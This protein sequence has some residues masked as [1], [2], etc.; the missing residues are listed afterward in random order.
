[1]SLKAP[2][3]VALAVT[4]T[5]A[6]VMA[7]AAVRLT[8]SGSDGASGSPLG[9]PSAGASSGAPGVFVAG[10]R[11]VDGAGR[12]IVLKGVN[13]SGSE[14]ACVDG[15]GFFDGPVDQASVDAMAS[16]RINT[17]RVP[18]NS[19]C[20]LGISEQLTS[21]NTSYA[22]AAYQKAIEDYVDLLTANGMYVILE[23]HWTGCGNSPCLANWLKPMPER[24]HA[25][26]FWGS[27]A[28]EFKGNT[29]ILFDLF[30]EPQGIDWTC[31]RDGGCTVFEG[32]RANEFTVEGMQPMVDAV[33]EAGA[34]TQPILLGGLE[35][36]NDM[37]GW[38]A[39]LPSDPSNALVASVHLYNFNS[40]CPTMLGS[41]SAADAIECFTSNSYNSI[42]D[43]AKQYPVVFGE[44]GQ[45]GCR[46]DFVDPML[47][48]LDERGFSV[49]GWAWNTAD[50]ASFPALISDYDGTPT[51]FGKAFQQSF[52][53]GRTEPA[54]ATTTE[55]ASRSDSTGLI[56]MGAPAF[57][58]AGVATNGNDADYATS[59]EVGAGE[60]GWLAYDLSAVPV[61]RR[62]SV[63]L[64]WYTAI[65]DG[66]TVRGIQGG[67]PAWSGR[68]YLGEYQI[69][70]NSAP[71]G[72]PAP[73]EGWVTAESV[74]GN[75]N[76]S[77]QHKV[78][79]RGSNWIRVRGSGPNGVAINV[80]VADARTDAHEGWLFLGDSITAGYAGH[81][82]ITD[83]GGA[84]VAGFSSLISD[85]TEGRHRPLSQ[86]SGVACSKASDAVVW[87]D[88]ILEDFHGKYVTLNFGGNDGWAG[89]G[90]PDA[91]YRTMEQ[92]VGIVVA[93]GKVPVVATITWPNNPG[94]WAAKTQELNDQIRKLYKAH[95][96]VLP[97]PDLYGLLAD[98]S[99]L[100]RG[101]GDPHPNDQGSALIRKAWRDM[102]LDRVFEE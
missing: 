4:L 66:H 18:L 25:T 53:A 6:L 33:R 70:V 93:H 74:T 35:Y 5:V 22:G 99:D 92:L 101:A 47:K 81:A 20:W 49:L 78:D 76:L 68:P 7:L 95:P 100:F 82:P 36:A 88:D 34:R 73:D 42:E 19:A 77:G 40:P 89:Q 52:T 57:A 67:C 24:A 45:D 71:G 60:S 14:Y 17:V 27:V 94:T 79:L 1:M 39:N 62:E 50:C 28:A 43:I 69:E 8:T 10:N 12:T 55:P 98:R 102:A 72:G 46:S 21:G 63:V 41:Q 11:L 84:V 75:Q 59:W 65:D 54:P 15:W 38:L 44:L 87:I 26:Q 30:N 31:W 29:S 13:R 64:A 91:Y 16:W 61:D 23:L 86:N 97:G 3:T 90:D 37:R 56:S 83:A 9:S 58:S 51:A 32:D 85:A 48:W 80:D 2:R 96:E